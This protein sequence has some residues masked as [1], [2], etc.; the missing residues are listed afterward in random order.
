MDKMLIILKLFKSGTITSNL[1][2]DDGYNFID[3]LPHYMLWK[4]PSLSLY[5]FGL[6]PLCGPLEELESV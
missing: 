3:H 6:P 2:L 5:T 1:I 4:R